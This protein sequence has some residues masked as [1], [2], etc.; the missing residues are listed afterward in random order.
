MPDACMDVTLDALVASGFVAAGD[1]YMSLS[2]V[3][4]IGHATPWFCNLS[5]LFT[6]LCIL[7]GLV[8]FGSFVHRVYKV[9]RKSSSFAFL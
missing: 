7:F 9:S 6:L 3:I 4:F 1:P 8:N 5:I 2:S